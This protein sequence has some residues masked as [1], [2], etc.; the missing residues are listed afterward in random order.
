MLA[1]ID[2]ERLIKFCMEN[3]LPTIDFIRVTAPIIHQDSERAETGS[4]AIRVAKVL[5]QELIDRVNEED[6]KINQIKSLRLWGGYGLWESKMIVE[7]L[8]EKSLLADMW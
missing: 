7:Y 6:S 1:N 3:G 5:P 4:F 8:R 2:H